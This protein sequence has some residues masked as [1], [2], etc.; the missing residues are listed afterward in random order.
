MP[1]CLTCTVPPGLFSDRSDS[2]S[3]SGVASQASEDGRRGE[4]AGAATASPG[5]DPTS[6]PSSPASQ[7]SDASSGSS[8]LDSEGSLGSLGEGVRQD[9]GRRRPGRPA[10]SLANSS[11][12]VGPED[13]EAQTLVVEGRRR[14][15]QVDYRALHAAMFGTVGQGEAHAGHGSW[16]VQRPLLLINK[17]VGLLLR[18]ASRVF[19]HTS[20]PA[21]FFTPCHH[22][23]LAGRGGGWLWRGG[24]GVVA[25]HATG[26]GPGVSRLAYDVGGALC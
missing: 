10:S 5:S 2:S 13:P 1:I 20:F 12:G 23:R 19:S 16:S 17:R 25:P 8:G 9:L 22:P 4:G 14:R 26:A 18:W 6:L 15:A 24:R 11:A 3:D 21:A 7:R